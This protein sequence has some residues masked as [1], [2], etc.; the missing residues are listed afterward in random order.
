MALRREL[1]REGER[2]PEVLLLLPLP[3]PPPPPPPLGAYRPFLAGRPVN[4]L[5]GVMGDLEVLYDVVNIMHFFLL[6]ELIC[7]SWTYSSFHLF[8][9]P[10]F[11]R[12]SRSPSWKLHSVAVCSEV[13]KLLVDAA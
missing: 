13:A 4:R 11:S 2:V 1:G 3:G 5:T 7:A 8:P 10:T 6:A 12:C 9:I